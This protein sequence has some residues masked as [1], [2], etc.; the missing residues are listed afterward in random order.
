MNFDVVRLRD[1]YRALSDEELRY[2][3]ELGAQAFAAP[4]IW[5]LVDSA[6]KERFGSGPPAPAIEA[7]PI[8]SAAVQ[9]FYANRGKLALLLLG[10]V[11]LSLGSVWILLDPP[12]APSLKARIAAWIGAPL[13]GLISLH[14]LHRLLRHRPSV[15]IDDEGLHDNASMVAGGLI[16]WRD[17]AGVTVYAVRT[18]VTFFA[19]R[20]HKMVGIV[21]KDNDKFLAQFGPLRKLLLKVSLAMGF[22]LVAIPELTISAKAESLASMISDRVAACEP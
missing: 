5:G 16:R 7:A 1:Y 6:F 11:A 17:I 20:N 21:L 2:Q 18:R 15:V 12:V 14:C 9:A 13:A 3:H 8:A 10:G 4:E 22:P 19:V